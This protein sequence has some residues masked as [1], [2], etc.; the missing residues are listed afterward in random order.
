MSSTFQVLATGYY[1]GPTEGFS[2]EQAAADTAR[3]FRVIA[4]DAEQNQRL[5][6]VVD[7]DRT[8][9]TKLEALLDVAG[10]KPITPVWIPEWRFR[11][12]FDTAEANRILAQCKDQLKSECRLAIGE[13]LDSS[14]RSVRFTEQQRRDIAN[15]IDRDTPDDLCA[16][17]EKLPG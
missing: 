16:W 12:E 15:A 13:E 17:M 6:A 10:Q 2:S 8:E 5:F 14:A 11:D 9:L 7:I 4:W 3:F 1:D